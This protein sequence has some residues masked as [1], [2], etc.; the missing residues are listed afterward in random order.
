MPAGIVRRMQNNEGVLATTYGSE[1]SNERPDAEIAA[2][3]PQ[4]G[5]IARVQRVSLFGHSPMEE[6]SLSYFEDPAGRIGRVSRVH[7]AYDATMDFI[8]N[9]VRRRDK[10]RQLKSIRVF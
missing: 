3:L 7:L 4:I 10:D 5:S 1:R 2:I 9:G 8:E 6:A